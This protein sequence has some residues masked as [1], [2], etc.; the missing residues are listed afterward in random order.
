MLVKINNKPIRV[1]EDAEKKG[2]SWVY[3]V[4]SSTGYLL[5]FYV[6]DLAAHV[7]LGVHP[8]PFIKFVG[9]MLSWFGL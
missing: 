9:V 1:E 2:I 8:F 3:L 6:L 5:V 4:V 7:F